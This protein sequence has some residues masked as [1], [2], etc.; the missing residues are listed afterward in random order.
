[1]IWII[2]LIDDC[3]YKSLNGTVDNGGNKLNKEKLENI[4]LKECH[5]KCDE[6]KGC[7]SVRYC[8]VKGNCF[9]KDKVLD[10]TEKVKEEGRKEDRCF[11]SFKTC[12]PGNYL[13]FELST[14]CL[15]LLKN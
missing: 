7:K 11:S 10:G 5:K 8:P 12:K 15:L 3:G 9:I 2:I 4:T 14:S 1:M 6:T 13:R